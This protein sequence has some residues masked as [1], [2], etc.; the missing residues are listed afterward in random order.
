MDTSNKI[1]ISILCGQLFMIISKHSVKSQFGSTLGFV[2]QD[3]TFTIKTLLH[4]KHN[5][6]L[7]TWVALAELVRY[8]DTPNHVL[9]IVILVKY[10]T[11]TK[12]NRTISEPPTRYLLW[13]TI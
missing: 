12:I 4:L 10:G 6:N 13:N 9:L 8:F 7:P 3:G 5:H 1:Y 2:C 11:H